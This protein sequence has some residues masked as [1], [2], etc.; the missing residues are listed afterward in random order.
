MADAIQELRL[1]QAGIESTKG[2]L[3]AATRKLSGEWSWEEQN[4]A[5]RSPHPAGVRA[6][7]GGAGVIMWKGTRVTV[8]TEL[9]A[10]EILWPLELGVRGAVTGVNASGDYTYTFD[11]QITTGIPDLDAATIEVVESDGTT[12]HVAR[13]FG[14]VMCESFGIEWAFNQAAKMNYVLFGRASQTTTPTAGLAT[15]TGLEPLVSALLSVYCDTSGANLGNTQLS[16]IVRSAKWNCTTGLAPDWKSDGRADKDFSKHK[17]GKLM[18]TLELVLELDATGAAKF[19]QYRT[20]DVL[21]IRLKNTGS[22][23][24]VGARYVQIDGAYRFSASP[25]IAPDGSQMLV[26]L[27]LESVYDATWAKTL[28]FTVMNALSAIT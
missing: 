4:P 15:Y 21:F 7:V 2:T 6:N 5:Y 24:A 17:V 8:N 1:L 23:A 20:N 16:G 3:V 28:H 14:Y 9:S 11:P 22:T 18:A 19:A 26:T 10:E 25:K 12:N 27:A 13:E